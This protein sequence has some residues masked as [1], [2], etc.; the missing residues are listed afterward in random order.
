MLHSSTLGWG[1]GCTALLLIA[2]LQQRSCPAD[3]LCAGLAPYP[4]QYSC[5]VSEVKEGGEKGKYYCFHFIGGMQE[6]RQRALGV[7]K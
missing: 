1:G 3:V 5:S 2:A 6:I 4:C 7:G